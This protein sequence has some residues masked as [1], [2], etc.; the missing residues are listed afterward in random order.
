MSVGCLR[1]QCAFPLPRSLHHMSTVRNSQLQAKSTAPHDCGHKQ[2]VPANM[3]RRG[4]LFDAFLDQHNAKEFYD[5]PKSNALL[6]CSITPSKP[7]QPFIRP[8]HGGRRRV[9]VPSTT[10]SS[11]PSFSA[12]PKRCNTASTFLLALLKECSGW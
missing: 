3:S 2:P 8:E 1:V 11:I 5:L 4:R 7:P 9:F 12:V 6:G 10:H